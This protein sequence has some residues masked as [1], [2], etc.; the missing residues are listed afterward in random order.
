MI[1]PSQTRSQPPPGPPGERRAVPIPRRRFPVLPRAIR[2]AS[3]LAWSFTVAL[4]SLHGLAIWLAMGGW[5][6]LSQPWPLAHHDHPFHF[7]GAVSARHFFAQTGTNA[8]YDPSFMS[9]YAA[10]ALSNPSSTLASVVV[11]LFGARDP[12]LVYKLYVWL[13]AAIVPWLLAAAGILWRLPAGA[14]GIAVLLDLIYVWTDFPLSYVEFGMVAY[15]ASVPL[16]LLTTAAVTVYLERGGPRRWLLAASTSSVLILV[17]I[18]APLVVA[19]ALGLA[20]LVAAA[21]A[22]RRGTPFS[23]GRHAGFWCLPLVALAANAF[24]WFPAL[25]LTATKGGWD[26][27]FTHP[28]SVAGRLGQIVTTE[29]P[30]EVVL[31]AGVPLGL[32]AWGRRRPVAAVGLGTFLAAGLFW[33]YLAGASRRLDPFQPGRQTYALYSAAALVAGIGAFEVAARVRSAGAGRLDRWL[34][35]AGIL[36]GLRL[37]GPS[38]AGSVSGRLRGPEPFLSSRPTPRL[39]WIVAGV[40]AHVKPGTRLLYEEGG[41]SSP[42]FPD[43][44][45]GDRYSGLL[46]Y[47]TGVEMLG[48]PFLRVMVKENFTQFGEGKLFG[49]SGWGR[50]HFVRYAGLYRPGAILCWSAHARAF[51]RANPDLIRILEDDG[52]LML[53]RVEGFDGGAVVGSAEVVAGPG[54]LE[55]KRLAAGVDGSVVLRYHSVPCLRTRPRVAWDAFRMEGDPVPFIRLKPPLRPVTLQLGFF[56]ESPSP[57][58]AAR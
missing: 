56:P 26:P 2:W 23:I 29:A 44:F 19:P 50:D 48:G 10:S 42:G 12:V 5:E 35:V 20:Y 8:G 45:R 52:V 40:G 14:I 16:G 33:G 22:S 58:A 38:L 31:L 1:E 54:R 27:S 41:A 18:T 32:A 3:L 7:H 34:A 39:R 13:G 25:Q 30:I 49:M 55:V 51:C 6:G 57:V 37:F 43:I 21:G 47:L 9:G 24:W 17:H 53:G 28:E 15:F 46:P 36:I 4:A 11:G